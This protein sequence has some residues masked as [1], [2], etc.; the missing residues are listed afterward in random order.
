M[1]KNNYGWVTPVI[2][3]G[4]LALGGYLLY[5]WWKGSAVGQA[6]GGIASGIGTTASAIDQGVQGLVTPVIPTQVGSGIVAP[7][8][9]EIGLP[10]LGVPKFLNNFAMDNSGKLNPM[11]APVK[12]TLAVMHD[13]TKAGILGNPAKENVNTTIATM[14]AAWNTI[15]KA[16]INVNATPNRAALITNVLTSPTKVM[17]KVNPVIQI[18]QYNIAPKVVKVNGAFKKVM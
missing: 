7:S 13:L 2:V 6:V 1:S 17:N 15:P 4:G 11:V 10:L 9:L 18:Q 8:P 12:A 3:L 14:S 16:K 5:N